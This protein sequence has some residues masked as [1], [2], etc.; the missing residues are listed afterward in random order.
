[1]YTIKGASSRSGVSVPLLRAWER[2]YGIVRPSRNGS[3]YRLYD[4]AAVDTL[5]TMRGLVAA[6]W[7][8]SEAARAISAGEVAV[9]AGSSRRAEDVRSSTDDLVD[10]FV[11]AA[12]ALEPQ[13]TEAALDE[14]MTIGSFEA[15]V[16]RLLMPA[17]RALGDAW[18][19]G[20][21]DVAGEHAASAAIARRLAAAF[22]GAGQGRRP[23]VVVGLPSG[24]RHELGALAFAVVLRRRGTAVVY[25]GPDVPP[26]S[27]VTAVRRTAAR[28]AVL[29]IVTRVDQ[30]PASDVVAALRAS[31]PHLLIA[32]GGGAA[33]PELAAA[34]GAVLLPS[35]IVDAADA[36]EAALRAAA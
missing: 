20:R 1:M 4:D 33:L 15:I 28:A 36:L 23:V 17:A 26:S 21:L 8:P 31:D 27:W 14:I 22:Q 5:S 2:R 29:G 12:I 30:S 32:I 6:G 9:V 34:S 35:L 25:L 18:E 13:A 11:T 19:A 7:T 3:G 24:S 10:R 16:D